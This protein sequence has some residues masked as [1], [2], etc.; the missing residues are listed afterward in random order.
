MGELVK[1]T[2]EVDDEVIE[3]IIEMGQPGTD[4]WVS[5]YFHEPEK[6]LLTLDEDI[7]DY[8]EPPVTHIVS[9][10]QIAAALVQIATNQIDIGAWLV[11]YAAI[12]L[13]DAGQV[14][15]DLADAVLQ[16]AI[17]DELIYG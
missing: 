17:F 4:Y 13:K 11:E 16:I 14:D 5:E 10:A 3:A 7:V 15:A 12:G 2:V 1:S 9:Y 8:D 6:R